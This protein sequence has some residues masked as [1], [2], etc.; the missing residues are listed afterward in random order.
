[1]KILH[2]VASYLPAMRYGGTIVSVHGLCRALAER[3]HDVH[4]F[5]TSVD[6]DRDSDVPHETPVVLDGVHV[7]YFRSPRFRRLYWAPG[8]RRT[9]R[10]H[11]G[12]FDVVHTHAIYLWPLWTAARLARQ[13]GVPYVVSP[14]GMLEKQLIEQKSAVWKAG[15]IGFIEKRTL[16]H[17]AAVHMTSRREAEQAAAFGFQLPPVHVIPNGVTIERSSGTRVSEGISDIAGSDPYVLFLGRVNW[18]KGL[19]RLIN[20]MAHAGNVRLLIAGNDE[21]EYA[22]VLDDLA[23]QAGVSDRVIFTGPVH[24]KDKAALLSSAR[25]LVLPSYSE[26]FGNVVVE[27]MAAGCPVIV[28]R[29]V[30]IADAVEQAGAGLVVDG[31]PAALGGAIGALAGDTRRREEMGARGRAAAAAQFSWPAVAARM[32]QLYQTVAAR[33]TVHA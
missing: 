15:L 1:M 22:L 29:E 2:V 8:L 30:G 32:E 4:V 16:E 9:L 19:D 21:E 25:V 27:A 7:W 6:G 13:A 33:R 3:G 14:R 26:N 5:T 17:A 24:G 11:V 10:R 12:E 20:A 28:T 31:T 23:R 18:K